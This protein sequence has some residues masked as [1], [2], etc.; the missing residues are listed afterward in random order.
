M[1]KY[2]KNKIIGIIIA[3]IIIAAVAIYFGVRS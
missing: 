2:W 3:V 1:L